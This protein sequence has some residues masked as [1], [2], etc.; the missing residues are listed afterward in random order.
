MYLTKENAFHITQTIEIELNDV[1]D[2][3]DETN[4]YQL[5]KE[6][7]QPTPNWPDDLEI[8]KSFYTN[9]SKKFGPLELAEN[10]FS[11]VR[12]VIKLGVYSTV[13]KHLDSSNNTAKKSHCSEALRSCFDYLQTEITK[14]PDEIRP[15]LQALVF[16]KVTPVEYYTRR[17]VYLLGFMMMLVCSLVVYQ[18]RTNKE[19]ASFLTLLDL[20]EKL[21][22][23][24][25]LTVPILAAVSVVRVTG[26]FWKPKGP[27]HK[28]PS[29]ARQLAEQ[30]QNNLNSQ[31]EK[32]NA[33]TTTK[34]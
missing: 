22:N 6:I 7:E 5:L 33:L 3:L 15:S 18:Y 24:V 14:L 23:V 12:L 8:I 4:I 30:E 31:K 21:A 34:K 17:S 2:D 27:S 1:L 19:D 29:V 13:K 26:L 32:G 20:A 11:D 25:L 16:S 28:I 10:Q 9:P